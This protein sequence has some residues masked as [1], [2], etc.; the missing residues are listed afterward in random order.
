MKL[1]VIYNSN[2]QVQDQDGVIICDLFRNPNAEEDGRAIVA[3]LNQGGHKAV[4]IHDVASIAI[5]GT[6]VQQKST[7]SNGN[8]HKMTQSERMKAMWAA[9]RAKKLAK[10][11]SAKV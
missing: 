4:E 7:E 6:T 10:L 1:P 11:V 2:F 9:K 5:P 8:R 3:M